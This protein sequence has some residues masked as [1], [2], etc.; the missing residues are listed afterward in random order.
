M[1][2]F[3]S[4]TRPPVLNGAGRGKEQPKKAELQEPRI[5]R[6]AWLG[7]KVADVVAE[8]L[9]MERTLG[10]KHLDEG[11]S[12]AGHHIR[13][14][15]GTLELE[16]VSGGTVW[17]TRPKPRLSQPDVPL[18]PSFKVDNITHLAEQLNSREVPLTQIYEQGWGA[19][20][21]FFDVERNLWQVSETRTEP[22]ATTEQAGQI[23]A[24][25]LA[26]EDFPAQLAFYRDVIGLPLVSQPTMPRPI[27]LEA[28][29]YQQEN[30][31]DLTPTSP[32]E[33]PA[34]EPGATVA[35]MDEAVTLG[36]VFFNDGARLALSPG[37]KRLEDGAERVWGRDTAFLPGFQTNN[38][39]GLV[40][41]LSAAGVKIDGP[42][43][44]YR[45]PSA[46]PNPRQTPTNSTAIR[47]TD[48]EGN[49]WQVFE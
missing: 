11:N 43:P 47:F 29:L 10:L 12:A 23:G 17:A 6:V 21:L 7:L 34:L 15:C 30:P 4:K 19:S 33:G 44:Y 22:A 20:F 2:L 32:D 16:L 24:L 48:P 18:I 28:E 36:A 13:Y 41:R 38:L 8:A 42:F 26:A 49:V 14:D 9:F 5:L 31:P 25:W 45:T 40:A 3:G 37:G 46:R 39:A 27:T 35:T 1:A